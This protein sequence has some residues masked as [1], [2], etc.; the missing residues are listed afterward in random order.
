VLVD[1]RAI[2]ELVAE[3]AA[4]RVENAEL[5]VKQTALEA[6]VEM[7][8]SMLTGGGNGSSAAP[9]VKGNRKERREAERQARKKRPQSFGRKL[10]KPTERV[11]HRL[12]R[13]PDCGGKL[14]DGW[15]QRGRQVIEIPEAPVRV[16]EHVA[17]AGWCGACQKRYVPKI[18]LSGQ[19]IGHSR[20]GVRL[21]SFVA[22]LATN[23]RMPH[24]TIQRILMSLYGLK[25]SV[26]EI[27]E[28]L[29]RVAERG[30]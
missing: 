21:M 15:V 11:E 9:F 2:E 27:S 17:I 28:I 22:D 1:T 30:Q 4:L 19:V 18:D 16:V 7:L 23:C 10:D 25:I 29:H 5:K 13:C 26:G 24:R 8:R 6:E 12:E 20:F 3:N 14:S